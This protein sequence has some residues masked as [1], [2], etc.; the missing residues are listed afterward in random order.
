VE[1]AAL[2][3]TVN[4][5]SG[6][7]SMHAIRRELPEAQAKAAGLPLWTV[8]LPSPCTKADYEARMAAACRRAAESGMTSIVFGDL[9]LWEKPT[10]AL[11]RQMIA[12]G[13][14]ARLTCIDTRVLP[15]EF[16]GREYDLRL[17]AA[18]PPAANACGENGEFP[19]FVYAGPFFGHP[20]AVEAG[21]LHQDGDFVSAD[22]L[23][24]AIS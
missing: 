3:T 23:P 10:A 14:R 2:L 18:L 17:L 12:G 15:R 19:S 6:R 24:A 1:V 20:I 21:E 4:G 11:A 5:A 16:A 22:I 13:L 8:P 7:L 9:F